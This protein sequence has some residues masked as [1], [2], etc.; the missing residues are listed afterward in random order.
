VFSVEA[1][2]AYIEQANAQVSSK[3]KQEVSA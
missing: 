1:L 2:N 3:S